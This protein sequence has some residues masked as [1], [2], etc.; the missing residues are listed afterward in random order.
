MLLQRDLRATAWWR[1]ASTTLAL[2]GFDSKK[3][4]LSKIVPSKTQSRTACENKGKEWECTM[5]N[6]VVAQRG[7]V[8]P[9]RSP[10]TTILQDDSICHPTAF[11]AKDHFIGEMWLF[12]VQ[13]CIN[14]WEVSLADGLGE[15]GVKIVEF[16]MLDLSD[17]DQP[18]FLL[19][20][21]I[22]HVILPLVGKWHGVL[23]PVWTC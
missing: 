13:R 15:E 14:T 12:M 17:L 10:L 7:D 16:S 21:F 19:D 22:F 4:D 3:W 23:S 11:G 8:L 9:S 18:C 6:Q 2:W 5:S 1:T 20:S